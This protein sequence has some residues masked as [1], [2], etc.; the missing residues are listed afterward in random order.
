[1]APSALAMTL[2]CKEAF[3][4]VY[5]FFDGKDDRVVPRPENLFAGRDDDI[6]VAQERPDYGPF[7]KTHLR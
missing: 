4:L 2:G 5:S 7:G 6:S 3:Y 1:M